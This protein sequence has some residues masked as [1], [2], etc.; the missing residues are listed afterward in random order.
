MTPAS[1]VDRNATQEEWDT[2]HEPFPET[3]AFE[4]T[5]DQLI[6]V[7]ISE[8]E[9]EQEGLDGKKRLVT[10]RTIQDL[11]GKKWGVWGNWAIDDAFTSIPKGSTVLIRFEGKEKFNNGAQTVNKFTVMRKKD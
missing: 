3:F 7:Y 5:G 2:V 10:V 4:N 6:G 11:E 9:L 1:N 8:K